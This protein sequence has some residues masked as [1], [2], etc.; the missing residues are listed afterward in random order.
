MARCLAR[1][2]DA[3]GGGINMPGC[4]YG[5]GFGFTIEAVIAGTPSACTASMEDQITG[6]VV[7]QCNAKCSTSSDYNGCFC[8]CTCPWLP[9][10]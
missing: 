1:R 3:G 2:D 5:S 9:S 8:P 7:Q 4:Q 6:Q 10:R